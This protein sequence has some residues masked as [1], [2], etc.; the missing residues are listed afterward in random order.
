MVKSASSKR[1][2]SKRELSTVRHSSSSNEQLK[3]SFIR[4]EKIKKEI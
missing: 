3:D 4:K 2:P 1:P